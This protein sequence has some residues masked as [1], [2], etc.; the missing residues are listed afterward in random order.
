MQAKMVRAFL[1]FLV[2]FA[3]ITAG[4]W[5]LAPR[6]SLSDGGASGDRVALIHLEGMI[7]GGT[8][9]GGL[10][11]GE[12]VASSVS[13]CNRLYQA[14]DDDAIKAVLLRVNSPGG[15]A[16]ASDE[17]YQA[18]MA[19]GA[20]KPVVVSMGDVAASGGYYIS[21]AASY[22]YANGA[23]LTGSI[24]VVFN[25]INWEEAAAKLG[26]KDVTLTAGEYKDIGT[27]WREM[28]EEERG[29]LTELMT[30]VHDQFIAA[31]AAGRENLDEPQ[32][33]ELATGMIYT[34]EQ[35]LELGLVDGLGGLEAA[36]VKARELAGLGEDAPVED[37]GRPS[38]WDEFFGIRAG[39]PDALAVL[40]R[41]GSNPLM[42]LSQG[43]YLNATLRDLVMR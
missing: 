39:R 3:V 21:S 5:L 40:D 28:T 8:G 13:L 18:V 19:V 29:M 35:A 24:G 41:L 34:G 16:A 22:I 26:L 12:S 4:A 10:L 14:R 6:W 37:Y 38:F 32:V 15:A 23:T 9:G 1:V 27:P 7:T 20:K 17:I 25:L 42:K 2:L 33:R 31:V 11:A 36:K 30:E 43:L